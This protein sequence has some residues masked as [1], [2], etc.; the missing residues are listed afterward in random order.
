MKVIFLDFDGVMNS[1]DWISEHHGEY[2]IDPIDPAA[3]KRLNQLVERTGA[4]VVISSVW[5][6]DGRTACAE[7]L[8][9]HGF[10]GKVIG[11]TPRGSNR[12]GERGH[13]IRDWLEL[14]API[15]KNRYGEVESFV[16]L[17]DDGDMADFHRFLV[18]TPPQCGLL[19]LHVDAAV[20]ILGE[21]K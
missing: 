7:K 1:V 18:Q 15:H 11:V 21:S 10:T 13:E 12:G 16:I 20:K 4:V 5:R 19:D 2:H 8:R 14:D 17:D 3:V 9:K 6:F